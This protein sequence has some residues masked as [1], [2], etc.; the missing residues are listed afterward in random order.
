MTASDNDLSAYANGSPGSP[1]VTTADMLL[2][3]R[4]GWYLPLMGCLIGLAAATAYVLAVPELYKSSA[5]ILIDKSV[6]RFFQANKILDQPAFDDAETGGQ[7][8]VLSSESIILPIVRSMD[9]A[10][11]PEFV[12]KSDSTQS[13]WRWKAEPPIEP[14]AA[15]ERMAVETFLKR[16]KVE[17]ED[18]AG[19][20]TVTFASRRLEKSRA[21]RQ[22]DSRFLCREQFGREKKVYQ[23]G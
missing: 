16:L 2:I 11:D 17:R 3:L 9:L 19:V 8:Y 5:R 20:I 6:N 1:A 15:L 14:D 18:V 23:D 22:R 10:H 21:H 4:R 12:G 13:F 7:V